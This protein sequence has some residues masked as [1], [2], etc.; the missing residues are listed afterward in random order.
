MRKPEEEFNRTF[1]PVGFTSQLQVKNKT[2][3]I[4]IFKGHLHFYKNETNQAHLCTAVE[5]SGDLGT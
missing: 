4:I 3:Q 2:N 1:V 5:N